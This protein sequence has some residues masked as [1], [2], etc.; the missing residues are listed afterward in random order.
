MQV[1]DSYDIIV[2]GD[3][4]G[5]LLAATACAKR[6]QKVLVLES[7]RPP[8]VAYEVPSGRFLGD[9]SCG[10]VLGWIPNSEL[11]IFL[12]GLGVYGAREEV[13]PSHSPSLQW[14]GP[15][16]R[17]DLDF[18]EGTLKEC[19]REMGP[20]GEAFARSVLGEM[21]GKYFSEGL[22]KND[23]PAH[24]KDIGS[25][26]PLLF[27]SLYSEDPDLTSY[28]QISGLART[29][30]YYLNGGSVGLKEKILSRF[31]LFGG[32]VKKSAEVEEIVF[33]R[34]KLAG[35]L[36]SSFEGFVKTKAL[37]GALPVDPYFRLFPEE[38]QSSSLSGRLRNRKPAW[39]RWTV[40]ALVK[41][42]ELPEGLGSHGVFLSKLGEPPIQLQLLPRDCYGGLGAGEGVLVIRSLFPYESRSRPQVLRHCLDH[43]REI[44][45]ERVFRSMALTFRPNEL[46]LPEDPLFQRFFNDEFWAATSGFVYSE[47]VFSS[48][49]EAIDWSVHGHANVFLASSDVYP[50]LGITGDLFT[51]LDLSKRLNGYV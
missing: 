31:R 51:G 21:E 13:F 44:L 1:R 38:A 26:V 10:P 4:L 28:Q 16:L 12:R 18:G 25:V 37:V 39:L 49:A 36:L 42:S 3:Q 11:D 23:W 19:T 7:D 43:V 33:E 34:G 6:G 8:E 50:H 9:F 20:H 45:G 30:V 47:P 15:R 24:W 32:A 41:Q 46:C 2:I 40:N 5:G 29:G 22:A 14:L 17:M 48:P 35:V 27:G